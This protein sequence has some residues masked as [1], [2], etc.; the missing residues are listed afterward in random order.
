MHYFTQPVP[1]WILLGCLI[2]AL[3]GGLIAIRITHDGAEKE[4]YIRGWYDAEDAAEISSYKDGP[5]D[6]SLITAQEWL[7]GIQARPIIPGKISYYPAEEMKTIGHRAIEAPDTKLRVPGYYGKHNVSMGTP[8]SVTASIDEWLRNDR[9]LPEGTRRAT[10]HQ[11]TA[12]SAEF[13][14]AAWFRMM[15]RRI[16]TWGTIA[17]YEISQWRKDITGSDDE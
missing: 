4:G 7:S 13:D 12:A 3:F 10:P 9:G 15:S 6:L 16:L 8:A 1:F 17:R 11:V 2:I 5:D 14:Q